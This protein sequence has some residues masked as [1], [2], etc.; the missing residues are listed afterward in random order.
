MGGHGGGG[1]GQSCR[2]VG[3]GRRE[4]GR[5]V[6]C[7]MLMEHMVTSLK[8]ASWRFLHRGLI[9]SPNEVTSWGLGGVRASGPLCRDIAHHRGHAWSPVLGHSHCLAASRE[10]GQGRWVRKSPCPPPAAPGASHRLRA[11]ATAKDA[12]ACGPLSPGQSCARPGPGRGTRGPP[13]SGLDQPQ[14]EPDR[15]FPS[16]RTPEQG[17]ASSAIAPVTSSPDPS[18]GPTLCSDHAAPGAAGRTCGWH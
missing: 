15:P 12:W 5:D 16:R 3:D 4:A 13:A 8:F 11:R 10:G 6:S 14:A 18:W 7:L 9:V 17:W 2:G 1:K